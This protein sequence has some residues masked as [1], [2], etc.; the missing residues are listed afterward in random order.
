M[1]KTTKK[2]FFKAVNRVDCIRATE[3]TEHDSIFMERLTKKRIGVIKDVL[4]E[5]GRTKY[6]AEREYFLYQES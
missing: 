1:K 6:P 5:H 2:Q 3:S 4:N